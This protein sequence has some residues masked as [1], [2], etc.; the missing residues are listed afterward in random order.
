MEPAAL[1][2]ELLDAHSSNDLPSLIRLYTYAADQHPSGSE[3]EAFYLTHAFVFALEAG[4]PE[5]E[6][7]N[8]RLADLGRTHRLAF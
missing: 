4:A 8:K 3:H 1:D 5:A 6:A 7:L 2:R